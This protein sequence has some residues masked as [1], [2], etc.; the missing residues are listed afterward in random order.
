LYVVVKCCKWDVH[1]A[2][3]FRLAHPRT[4]L[5]APFRDVEWAKNR[6]VV[7]SK[8]EVTDYYVN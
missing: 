3:I 4:S 1:P 7:M 8:Y 6:E 2:N 5:A